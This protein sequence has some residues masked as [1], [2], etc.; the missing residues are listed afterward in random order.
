MSHDQAI[1]VAASDLPNFRASAVAAVVA[2]YGLVVVIAWFGA[3][4]FTYYES[5]GISP[6]VA[7]SPYMSWIYDLI[8][9]SAFGRFL[10]TIELIT[11]A[12]LALKPWFPKASILGGVLASL[13]FLNTLGF[14]I[15]TPDIGE[16]SAG[17]FPILSANGQFLMKDIALFGLSLFLLAD[18]IDATRRHDRR[19]AGLR[20]P[21]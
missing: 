13:F 15:T 16:A 14:M 18:A 10:G 5:H 7:N 1:G 2:R 19:R 8:S 17:G 12:L 11:A 20:T 9:I 3:M 21:S 4:K 6:L